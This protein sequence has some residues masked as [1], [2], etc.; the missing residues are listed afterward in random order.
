MADKIKDCIWLG[1]FIDTLKFEGEIICVLQDIPKGEPKGSIWI[2]VVRSTTTLDDSQLIAEQ[3]ANVYAQMPN[4]DLISGILEENWKKKIKTLVHCMAGI[5][6]SPL[7]IVHWLHKFHGF[8]Y[9]EAY[10]YVQ[11]I[12]PQV[13]NRL[14]WLNMTYGDHM[15]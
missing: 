12:R 7:A 11:K 14:I 1:D 4:L 2:P 5:E 8:S 3:D 15:S 10:E 9:N 6:R 13:Q